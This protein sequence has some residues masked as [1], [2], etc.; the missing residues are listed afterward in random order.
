MALI[1]DDLHW[2]DRSTLLL[3]RHL[4]RATVD[5]RVLVIGAFRDASLDL[6]SAF[7][8]TLA[9][10]RRLNGVARLRLGGLDSAGVGELVARLADADVDEEL[11]ALASEMHE[12]TGGNAFLVGELWRHLLETGS[13]GETADG[14]RLTVPLGGW[15][16]RTA[17]ARWSVSGC[18]A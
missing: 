1:F 12:L 14:W 13:L 6:G 2:A 15:G 17:S 10:L 4:V 18:P 11:T 8:D 16:P 7:T 9:D 3:L 5:A